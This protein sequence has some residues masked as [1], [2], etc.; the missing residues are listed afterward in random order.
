MPGG[1]VVSPGFT[2]AAGAALFAPGPAPGEP[3]A[4]SVPPPPLSA[5]G[6][7]PQ[8]AT[9]A[10]ARTAMPSAPIARATAAFISLLLRATL[11]PALLARARDEHARHEERESAE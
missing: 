3:L 7:S 4:L 6:S 5:C 9:E 11:F 10:A 8:A 2:D 1:G